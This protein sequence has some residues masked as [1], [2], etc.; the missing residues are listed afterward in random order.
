MTRV[1]KIIKWI[2]TLLPEIVSTVEKENKKQL[3]YS[4]IKTGGGV[5]GNRQVA[6]SEGTRGGGSAVRTLLSCEMPGQWAS[7]ASQI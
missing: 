7:G 4:S 5:R 3:F 1:S 6:V 2:K